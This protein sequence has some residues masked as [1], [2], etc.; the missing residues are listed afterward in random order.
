MGAYEPL[1][2]ES[3]ARQPTSLTVWM[4]NRMANGAAPAERE[5]LLD[6]LRAVTAHPLATATT[7]EEAEELMTYQLET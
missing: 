6:V 1:L 5:R 4:V 7:R 2:L 3:I